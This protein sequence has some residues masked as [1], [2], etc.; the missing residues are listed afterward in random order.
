MQLIYKMRDIV[1]KAKVDV[2]IKPYEII[3]LSEN[4]GILEFVSNSISVDEMK[5]KSESSN[6]TK[7]FND[8]FQTGDKIRKA[9]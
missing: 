3:V 9:K 6:L 8:I 4:S 7:F 2:F 5:K 1:H